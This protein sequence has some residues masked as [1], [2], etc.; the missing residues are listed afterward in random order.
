MR[1]I[2]RNVE[3]KVP[4]HAQS[5]FQHVSIHHSHPRR[6]QRDRLRE[7]RFATA[8]DDPQKGTAPAEAPASPS[9]VLHSP[10]EDLETMENGAR[11]CPTR[12]C[13][14]L[15]AAAI[16]AVL[17]QAVSEEETRTAEGLCRSP[18]AGSDNGGRQRHV[19]RAV[20]R[21][22]PKLRKKPSQTRKTFL[23]NH[24][25]S[26]FACWVWKPAPHQ[27]ILLVAT[28]NAPSQ[29]SEFVHLRFI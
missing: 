16:Q 21:L 18:E 6:P 2:F 27:T 1:L 14:E 11:R 26:W 17:E 5:D 28:G 25:V 22:M 15:A 3:A 19:G 24:V 10:D 4:L 29:F 8:V 23:T 20:S 7:C 9:T 12:Y 13:C